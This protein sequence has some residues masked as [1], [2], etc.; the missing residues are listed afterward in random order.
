LLAALLPACLDAAPEFPPRP[1]I[2]P[3]VFMGQVE[4]P[5]SAIY[6]G[7][8]P[9]TLNVPFRS[10]DVNVDLEARLFLDLVAGV[11]SQTPVD[12]SSVPAST[13][14]DES[15]SVSM[16]WTQS[17]PRGCHSITMILTY[18]RNFDRQSGLPADQ[19]LAAL[20]IWWLSVSDSAG[21]V[22]IGSCPSSS[23]SDL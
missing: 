1:Q 4:P 2:P 18:E 23:Q 9:F 5:V 10:E 19:S 20:V 15:R 6:D 8:I 12:V 16:D 13:F 22:S 14:D 3:I 11:A 21:D 7:P 17:L